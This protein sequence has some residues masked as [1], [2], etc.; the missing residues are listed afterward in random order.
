MRAAVA[1]ESTGRISIPAGVVLSSK[2]ANRSFKASFTRSGLFG[3]SIWDT[4]V[5]LSML[6]G[7]GTALVGS[8]GQAAQLYRRGGPSLEMTDSHASYF[9][10]NLVV[11]RAE[12]RLAFCVYRAS[13]FTEVRGLPPPGP[14]VLGVWRSAAGHGYQSGDQAEMAALRRWERRGGRV[15]RQLAGSPFGRAEWERDRSACERALAG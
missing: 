15:E 12:E 8:F 1:A 9:Q 14:R 3:Q 13:A 4:R 5:V 6:V 10:N 11:L 7:A 2:R